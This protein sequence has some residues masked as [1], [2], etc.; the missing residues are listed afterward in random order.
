MKKLGIVIITILIC[1]SLGSVLLINSRSVET[2]HTSYY[3]IV[4]PDK[5]EV[6]EHK[7]LELSTF[8]WNGEKV[9]SIE[10]FEN[11]QYAS[12]VSSIIHN[13]FGMHSYIES[14]MV[15]R[16]EKD[17][18]LVKVVVG[19]EQSAAEM[20]M[21]RKPEEKEEH[22]IWTNYKDTVIDFFIDTTKI[23]E[24]E[25]EEIIKNFHIL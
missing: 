12:S 3:S 23:K 15:I 13:I 2:Y 5:W 8:L 22:Y 21:K 17:F 24:S 1:I 16:D 7:D 10:V 9:A 11:C 4:V 20:E 14:D 25:K 19:Y 18:Q 6:Q